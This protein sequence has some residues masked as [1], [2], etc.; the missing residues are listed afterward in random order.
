MNKLFALI[1]DD[2]EAS[3]IQKI[4]DGS[5]LKN[6]YDFEICQCVESVPAKMKNLKPKVAINTIQELAKK[7]IEIDFAF[8][9]VQY[10]AEF[11]DDTTSIGANKVLEAI[12]KYFPKCRIIVLSKNEGE[13]LDRT[14]QYNG[15]HYPT[16]RKTAKA[17][18][19]NQI[20]ESQIDIWSQH[21]ASASITDDDANKLQSAVINN[22]DLPKLNLRKGKWNAEDVFP[23]LAGSSIDYKKLMKYFSFF[24]KV[25]ANQWSKGVVG[26]FDEGIKF[27]YEE[28]YFNPRYQGCIS[29]IVN[30]RS[31][32][33]LDAITD[34]YFQT[35]E[36]NPTTSITD[37]DEKARVKILESVITAVAIKGTCANRL[38]KRE[39]S[40]QFDIGVME[41]FMNR[42]I[43]RQLAICSYLLFNLNRETIY[44]LLHFGS[45]DKYQFEGTNMT[46]LITT[47]LYLN[48]IETGK[49]SQ[50]FS[51]VFNDASADERK[52]LIAYFDKVKVK[53]K[54]VEI[55]TARKEMI[56]LL[57]TSVT[58]TLDLLTK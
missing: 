41:L 11:G 36:E 53:M 18:Y 10:E 56:E 6:H 57:F 33:L 40:G 29:R 12:Q 20:I 22:S 3:K 55:N 25:G 52:F 4:L 19:L 54:T 34:W 15:V 21:M 1:V 42:L 35:I 26:K 24:P 51:K 13:F 44:T 45:V 39:K 31:E 43:G 16:I 58:S 50:N 28:L 23:L 48:D 27:Y 30:A 9:D 49:R 38:K 17:E 2:T 7:K 46:Q 5:V 32:K 37:K 47:S 8:V 14:V